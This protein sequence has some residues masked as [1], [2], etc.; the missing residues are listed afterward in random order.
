MS[1]IT[2]QK[3]FVLEFYVKKM[4]FPKEEFL[5]PFLVVVI[6]IYRFKF[7]KISCGIA[8]EHKNKE[9]NKS[10]QIYFIGSDQ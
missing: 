2:V 7:G 8:F 10:R 6:P 4:C 5:H 9:A 3:L 1:V